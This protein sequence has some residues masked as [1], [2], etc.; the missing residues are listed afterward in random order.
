MK[1]SFFLYLR[2]LTK[3]IRGLSCCAL[4]ATLA[5]AA[6]A[7][8]PQSPQLAPPAAIEGSSA[9]GENLFTG[10]S[11]FRNRGPACIACHSVA[12]LSFPNGGTMAPDL[13]QTYTKLG[14][15]GTAAAM[16]TLFF[17]TMI[18]IYRN[19]QLIPQEQA[20]LVAFF[21]RSAAGTKPESR[22][23][24]EILILAAFVLA[25]IFVFITAFVW[26]KRLRSVRRELVA[27]A[28]RRGARP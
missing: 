27:T 25:I 18:P 20:D 4:A 12:G 6:F 7:Q 11:A 26:R 21:Q 2:R 5:M 10:R 13:T 23:T 3:S 19:H 14:P 8:L 24:T 15:E 28:T 17:P 9:H 1:S 22:W 16:Q